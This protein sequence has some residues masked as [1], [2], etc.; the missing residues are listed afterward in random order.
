MKLRTPGKRSRLGTK[1]GSVVL[2]GILAATLSV[3]MA[4]AQELGAATLSKQELTAGSVLSTDNVVKAAARKASMVAPE[5]L[6]LSGVEECYTRYQDKANLGNWDDPKYIAFGSAEYNTNPNPFF[7]NYVNGKTPAVAFNTNNKSK[8]GGKSSALDAYNAGTEAKYVWDLLP[9]VIVGVTDSNRTPSTVDYSSDEYAPAAAAANNV[10]D[11]SPIGVDMKY[12]TMGDIV[13]SMY[14]IAEA[15]DA[16]VEN[17]KDTDNPKQLRYG[18]AVEIAKTYES[19]WRGTQGYILAKLSE[20]G[21]DKKMYAIVSSYDDSSKTYRLLG[22]SDKWGDDSAKSDRYYEAVSIVG[23]NL[24][25]FYGKD[26]TAEELADAELIVILGSNQKVEASGVIAVNDVLASM[27]ASLQNKTYYVVDGVQSPGGCN[28]LTANSSDNAQHMGRL[29]GCLYPEYVDQD[30]W[31]CYWFDNL[32]HINTGKLAE[33]V[34]NTMD[35]TVNW[36]ASGT[37]RTQWTEADAATYKKADVQAR[38]DHGIAYLASLGDAV[39]ATLA[40]NTK[41]NGETYLT[42]GAYDAA[43]SPA[44]YTEDISEATVV[45]STTSYAY[46]GTAKT[47][48]V[49]VTLGVKE[50][51]EETDYDVAYSDNKNA[52]TATITITGKGY[53]TGTAKGTFEITAKSLSSAKVSGLASKVYTGKAITQAPTVKLDSTTLKK[54]T[55]YTVAYKNNKNVGTATVTITGKGNYAGTA[56]ATFKITKAENTMTAKAAKTKF[57]KSAKAQKTTISVSN[58]KGKV[59]YS[60]NK[61]NVTV[62]SKGAVTIAKNF[63]GSAVITVKAAGNSSYKALTKKITITVS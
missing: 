28:T 30:D 25:E 23:D 1:L 54:G 35:Y 5:I 3:P 61:K 26:V 14:D 53:Y 44:D 60:S 8:S 29:L 21:K 41:A 55:D 42:P 16:V 15:G 10:T 31:V 49:T 62:S 11:Y 22:M 17:T 46:D 12:S 20:E 4:A 6:G 58:A 47:P 9:D 37:D 56:K 2:S 57:K 33:F 13:N 45:A 32:Y 59:T 40:L 63:K 18:S 36:D 48:E 24:Q 50:L 43:S 38:L 19:F 34:G 51:S 7:V 52:G 39:P 27:P